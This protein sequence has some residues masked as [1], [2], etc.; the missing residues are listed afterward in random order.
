M[1]K[2]TKDNE[3]LDSLD[4]PFVF[5]GVVTYM[6]TSI[7]FGLFDEAVLALM[8]CLCIDSDLNGKPKHN[9]RKLISNL[10]T[11]PRNQIRISRA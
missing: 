1:A 5:V 8:T 3:E 4:A 11:S 9:L 7:F 10:G 6:A 2:V